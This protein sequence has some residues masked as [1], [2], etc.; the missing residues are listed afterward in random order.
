M[1]GRNFGSGSSRPAAAN[2]KGLGISCVA[3]EN[4]NSLFFRNAINL[5]LPVTRCPGVTRLAREGNNLTV[6]LDEG[7]ITNTDTGKSLPCDVLPNFLMDILNAGGII[8][9]LRSQGYLEE[10]SL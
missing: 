7:R 5:G 9:I 8:E 6:S 3:A 2:L 10:K 4:V 1:A